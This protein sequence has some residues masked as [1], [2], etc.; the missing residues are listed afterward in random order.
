MKKSKVRPLW[1]EKV[2]L[3]RKRFWQKCYSQNGEDAYLQALIGDRKRGTYVDVGGFHPR[4]YSN[5]RLLYEQGWSGVNID[6]FETKIALFKFDRPNDI[7]VCCAVSDK[8]GEMIAYEFP[9]MGALDTT[10]EDIANEWAKKFG[11]D[12]KK[13]PVPTRSLNDVLSD[14]GVEKI[15][16]LNIDVEGAE[17]PVLNGFDISRFQPDIISIEIHGLLAEVSNTEAYQLLVS[18]GMQMVACLPPTYF[19]KRTNC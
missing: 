6:M 10:D 2:R 13:R 15:D 17:I 8:A 12:Y 7:N 16:Y 9:G 11:L 5:T 1:V 3:L 4:K 14:N 18:A 19:F